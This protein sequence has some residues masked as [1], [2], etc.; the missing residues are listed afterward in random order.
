MQQ[1]T[2]QLKQGTAL[3]PPVLPPRAL[4]LLL[5]LPPLQLPVEPQPPISVRLQG[6]VGPQPLARQ[7][8]GLRVA[9]EVQRRWAVQV[10]ERLVAGV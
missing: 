1:L 10:M 2:L 4:Q 3:L 8:R 9:P 6:Q 7:Q 5:V